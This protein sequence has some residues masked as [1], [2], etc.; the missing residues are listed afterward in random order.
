MVLLGERVPDNKGPIMLR[1]LLLGVAVLASVGL[2]FV[3]TPSTPVSA[4][5]DVWLTDYQAALKQAKADNKPLL[6]RFR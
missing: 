3:A 4:E 6:V 1:L 5:G 2:G